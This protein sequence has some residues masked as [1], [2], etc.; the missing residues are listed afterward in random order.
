MT[1]ARVTFLLGRAGSGKTRRLHSR[2]GEALHEGRRVVVIVPEQFTFETERQLAS[3]LGGLMDIEVYSFSSLAE[4]TLEGSYLGFLSRQG[5]RM[6]IRKTVNEQGS[7]LSVFARVKDRPGFS[8]RL[9]ELFT[10]CKRYEVTPADLLDGA[11]KAGEDTLLSRKLTELALLYGETEGYISGRYMDSED[12]FAA[13]IDSLPSSPI[14]GAE[15]VIDDFDLLTDQLYHLMAAM[16]LH[17]ESMYISLR[18]D[19]EEGRDAK[20]FAP[21]RRAY[22]RLYNAARENGCE[23]SVIRLPE[24]NSK[25]Q[26][27]PA[28]AHLE[29]EVFAYPYKIYGGEAPSLRIAAA[30]SVSAE[31]EMAAEAVLRCAQGGM[32]YRDMAV[33]AADPAY[34]LQL[35]RSMQ[36]RG[37]PCF[38]DGARKLSAYGAPRLV[39]SALK[40]VNRGYSLNYIMD[41]LRTGLAGAEGGD[42][43]LFEN[44]ALQRG[45]GGAGFKKTFDQEIPEKVR[46]LI[47]PK[48]E[49]FHTAFVNAPTARDKA[50]ALFDFMESMGLYDSINGLVERLRAEG[51]HQLAEENAQVYRLMLTVLDQLY[52]IMGESAVSARRFAAI[53]EEGFDSYEISAIPATADQLLLGTL[54]RTMAK[55]P[56]AMFI[57]GANEG[58]FPHSFSDDGMISDRELD[59][60][61]AMG[62][63]TWGRGGERAENELMDIYCAL[64][65]PRELL[66]ISYTMSA[67]ADAALPAPILER[68][69]EIFPRVKLNTDLEPLPPVSPKGGV[70]RLAREL[71][72]YGDDLTP[73]E[74]LS[75]LYAWYAGKPEYRSTLEG[76]EDALYYRC[77]PEPFGHELSLKLYGDP[78]FGSA[79]RLERYNACPFDHFVTYGLRATER[80][81]FRE[82]P[83]D[84]GVF[85]HSA[86]DSFVREA[87]KRD[88][89]ALED[90]DCD[91][92]IDGIMPPLMAAHNN[93]VLLSSTRNMALCARLIRKVKATARAIVRQVRSGGFMPEST[94]VSFGMGGLPALTLELPT[95]ERFYISGRID[96]IDGCS[97]AGQDY[98]RII[99]YKTGGSEFSYTRLYYGLSL[100]LPLYAAAIGAVERARRAA[101]MYYM[102]VDSP[103]VSETEEAAANE[104]AVK[105]KV[106]ESFRLSGLT[107]SDP[108]VVEAAAGGECPAIARGARTVIPGDK[109]EGLIGYALKRSTETLTE[110]FEGRA[111]VSP[112]KLKSGADRCKSCANRSVCGFDERIPGCKRRVFGTLSDRAFFERIGAAEDNGGKEGENGD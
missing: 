51:R 3:E 47:I 111:E 103:V 26:A 108:L 74:G 62:A 28:L 77:S 97:I 52:A 31:C 99:D 43:D 83:L 36:R 27:D 60:L 68:I 45:T 58:S 14:A 6:A 92:I 39:L 85:C 19:P 57:L 76:L 2:I 81:E 37:I 64:A 42:I 24:G 54:G 70:A 35:L 25:R 44:Y 1:P 48:I 84:E 59:R 71:R 66:Y 30:T 102:K 94:E 112:A 80:R 34:E 87:M 72:A 79:T 32:R 104:E 110:I 98:Y 18:M 61:S 4:K 12:M 107:L 33:I 16:T 11:E 15:V 40:C 41:M 96:R 105:K 67:G 56:R 93:G 53:L 50:A 109:L 8:E 100:Q 23:I 55:S 88:I 82:R 78:L 17:A 63:R 10:A 69:R 29:A 13:L 95:G 106:M 65:A 5:R 90:G 75:R 22:A 20:L 46:G 89:S 86:L 49:E 73:W 7:R 21:K 91:E 38:S 9:C 101:G